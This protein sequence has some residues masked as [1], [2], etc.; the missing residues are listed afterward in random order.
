MATGYW[1]SQ[2]IYVAA[3]LGIADLLKDGPKSCTELAAATSV[4]ERS[5]FRIMRA[6]AS[7]EIFVALLGRPL[8]I[9]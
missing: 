8:C 5:L 4:D 3:K 9:V 6:L 1:L 7:A 2:A